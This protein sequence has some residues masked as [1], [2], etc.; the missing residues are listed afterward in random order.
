[1][2]AALLV[3]NEDVTEL[4]IVAE[5]VVQRQDHAARVAE[6]DL[7]AL[8]QQRL[9]DDV[10]ADPRAAQ[11]ARL[12]EHLL[13]GSLDRGGARRSLVRDVAAP[14]L[15]GV[16]ARRRLCVPFRDRHPWALRC[17]AFRFVADKRKTLASRRGSWVIDGRRA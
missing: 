4:G 8:A 3:A 13:A 14:R 9:A 12:V 7:D 16:T 2:G 10:G 6:E 1:M 15:R 17:R 5:H 11:V